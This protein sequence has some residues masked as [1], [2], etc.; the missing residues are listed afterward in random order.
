MMCGLLSLLTDEETE[1]QGGGI[2]CKNIIYLESGKMSIQIHRHWLVQPVYSSVLMFLYLIGRCKWLLLYETFQ[3]F[4]SL[5]S[6]L[7]YAHVSFRFWW[8]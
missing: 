4:R 3:V 1:I 6:F 5:F 8:L 2:P 7:N